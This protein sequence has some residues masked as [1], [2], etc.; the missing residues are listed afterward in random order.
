ML[1]RVLHHAT[2]VQ[3]NGESYRL[4]GEAAGRHH[5]KTEELRKHNRLIG[6]AM[7][8]VRFTPAIHCKVGQILTGVD[9]ERAER[10]KPV[11]NADAE[12][13][14]PPAPRFRQ[15][16]N[17]IANFEDHDH[18]L[19]G[20]VLDWHRIVEHRQRSSVPLYLMIFSPTAA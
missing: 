17:G 9:T 6:L 18:G 5:G 7:G 10:S 13:E 3:I 1:D 12:A 19:G 14:S 20:R 15:G 2:V 16:S 4:K 8:W 11:R